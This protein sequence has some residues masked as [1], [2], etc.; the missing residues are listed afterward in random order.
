[1][2]EDGRAAH[3]FIVETVRT[4]P[5]EVTL[6]AVGPLTNLAQ[7]LAEAPGIAGLVREVVVIGGA[8]GYNGELGNV[9]PAAEAN[10][11]GDPHA[12]DIVFG[13]P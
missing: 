8:F 13:A 7:A 5:G 6:L 1:M 10:A 3:R 9:T 4:H 2:R 11:H 12:A